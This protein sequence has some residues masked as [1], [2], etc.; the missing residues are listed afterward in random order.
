MLMELS[1]YC[2]AFQYKEDKECSLLFSLKRA[3][4]IA[5]PASLV[6]DIAT[7]ALSEEERAI[8]VDL[9]FLVADRQAEKEELLRF[10]EEINAL[11]KRLDLTVVMNLDCN[12]ACVYCFEGTRKGKLFLSSETADGLGSFVEQS[13]EGKEEVR[14]TFYGGEPLLSL[15]RIIGISERV[16]A[17]AEGRGV[18]YGFSLITNGTLL[19]PATVERLL[20]LGLNS[21]KVTLDGPPPVHDSFRPFLSG[22]GSFS[23]ILRNIREVCDL[24]NI[25]IGGNFTKDNY[26]EFPRLLDLL[27]EEGLT[28]DKI[29]AVKFDPVSKESSEFALPDFNDGCGSLNEPWLFEASVFL[30]N[31]IL[32]R[33]YRT[34]RMMPSPCMIEL[35]DSFIVNYDGSLYK[36]PGLIGREGFCAGH[37][38]GGVKDIAAS[39]C[40]DNWKNEECLS[41]V[42]LPLC[43]GGCRY[44]RLVRE[45]SMEGV[46]C[47][48]PYF[49]AVLG[50]LVHQDL[51]LQ[52]EK[53][54]AEGG[55]GA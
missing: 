19:T 25:Q 33:G 12:L 45:G 24:T 48:K 37:L 31:E 5:L 51:G 36:C 3:S 16:K 52:Q 42:Y 41:C 28:P 10:M 6:A 8:L 4:S 2:T 55:G 17:L 27:M 35:K 46:D 26:R 40:L 20:P 13:I 23:A 21:A 43:F 11:R 7:G 53:D 38:T 9:G 29:R 39:H 22:K 49:D 34:P 47:K 15:E 30:R 50:E 14:I 32:K 54:G 18:R 44:L 1:A